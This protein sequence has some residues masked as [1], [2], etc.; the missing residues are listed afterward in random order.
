MRTDNTFVGKKKKNKKEKFYDF[1]RIVLI[2]KNPGN[3]QSFS[4]IIAFL[5]III[6]KL[7]NRFLVVWNDLYDL[8]GLVYSMI[9][10]ILWK[11][12]KKTNN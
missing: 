6:M 4:L 7:F 3:F 2:K 9:W 1:G 5:L 10:S 8:Y 11:K 12:L